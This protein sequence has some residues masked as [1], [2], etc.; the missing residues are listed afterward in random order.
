MNN[1]ED[2]LIEKEREVIVSS[3]I[4]TNKE[5]VFLEYLNQEGKLAV[6]LEILKEYPP[7]KSYR[8]RTTAA[9]YLLVKSLGIS[10]PLIFL[11]DLLNSKPVN[12]NARINAAKEKGY[13][14]SRSAPSYQE[15]K[16]E[17]IRVQSG[18]FFRV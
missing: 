11:S 5:N 8:T 7:S 2:M 16:D 18:Q 1:F 17:Y 12:I 6:L 15:A 3:L 10:R 14:S 13:L 9:L 4:K